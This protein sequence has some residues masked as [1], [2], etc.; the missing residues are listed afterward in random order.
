MLSI[1][2][3]ANGEKEKES[4]RNR[5][6]IHFEQRA[7]LIRNSK[8]NMVQSVQLRLIQQG[9]ESLLDPKDDFDGNKLPLKRI[10]SETNHRIE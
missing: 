1:R 3:Q 6:K 8:A 2:T 9:D 7:A 10:H 5:K 4:K